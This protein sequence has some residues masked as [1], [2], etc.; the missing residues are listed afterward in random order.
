VVDDVH[1]GPDHLGE[2]GGVADVPR[3]EARVLASEH[4]IRR[5]GYAV[6]DGHLVALGDEPFH[7]VAADEAAAA[8]DHYSG[9]AHRPIPR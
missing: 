3:D 8:G 4:L 2:A 5:R 9:H 1:P 6:E 7:Q